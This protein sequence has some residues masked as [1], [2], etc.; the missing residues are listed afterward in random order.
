M[1]GYNFRSENL[2]VDRLQVNYVR[3]GAST[4]SNEVVTYQTGGAEQALREVND[5][6]SHCPQGPVASTIQG[7]ER[8]TYRIRRISGRRLLP[9]A[10]ALII[11]LTATV[12]GRAEM[13]TS[14]AVYQVRG[15]VLSG[16][17]T[18]GGG[19]LAAQQRVALHAA[20]G[21]SRNLSST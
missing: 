14:V 15:N 1:C 7:V 13:A 3:H 4:V 16:V 10:I 12:N 17:Y 20:Q 18:L 11:H 5:A 9:G 2:R 19:D 8:V 21:S 6:V